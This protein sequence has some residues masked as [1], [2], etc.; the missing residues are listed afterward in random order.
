MYNFTDQSICGTSPGAEL[1]EAGAG[2]EAGGLEEAGEHHHLPH[3]GSLCAAHPGE[4][5]YNVGGALISRT[6]VRP[7]FR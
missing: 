3:A 1:L 7:P 5:A 2:G 6:Q 4:A